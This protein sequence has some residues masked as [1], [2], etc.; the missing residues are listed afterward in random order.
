MASAA[1]CMPEGDLRHLFLAARKGFMKGMLRGMKTAGSG[2]R[3]QMANLQTE[4]DRKETFTCS[5]RNLS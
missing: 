4:N 2:K 5:N 3:M 1:N